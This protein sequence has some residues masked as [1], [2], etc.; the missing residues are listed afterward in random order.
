MAANPPVNI[1]GA[2]HWD[3]LPS[4][5]RTATP[6]DTILEGINAEDSAGLVVVL[7][8][9]AFTTAASLTLNVLGVDRVSGKTWTIAST[10]AITANGTYALCVHPNNPTQ[11][12]T[13]GVQKAQ[14]QIPDVLQIQVVHGNGNSHT[15][16]VGAHFTG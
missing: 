5:A 4:A 16:S 1:V 9:T 6:F 12:M 3:I 14:G 11:A 13:N 8:L 10:A 15:Y 7:D 2:R